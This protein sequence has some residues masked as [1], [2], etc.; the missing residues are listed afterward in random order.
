MTLDL[1]TPPL[2][3]ATAYTRVREPGWANGMTGSSVAPP[4]RSCDCSAWR[5]SGVITPKSISTPVT[6]GTAATAAVMSLRSLSFSGQPATVSSSSTR[7]TPSAPIVGGADHAQLG[8]GPADLR[9]V[10]GGQGGLDRV[11]DGAGGC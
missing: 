11:L 7:T 1:P 6:P 2:P 10:D 3:L 8:D 4:P 5:C 9:V